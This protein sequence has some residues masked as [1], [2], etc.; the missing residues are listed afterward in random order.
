[1]KNKKLLFGILVIVIVAIAGVSLFY[2]L[3][4][5]EFTIAWKSPFIKGGEDWQPAVDKT[6]EKIN[7]GIEA[8]PIARECYNKSYLIETADYIIEG[9]IEKVEEKRDMETGIYSYAYLTIEDYIKGKPLPANKLQINVSVRAPY[10]FTSYE[11]KK[12]RIYLRR[13]SKGDIRIF[14]GNYGVE[15]IK[16][17]KTKEDFCG[18]ST[19]GKCSSDSDCIVGGCSAQVCQS[20][21]EK[22]IITTCEWRDCYNAKE[23]NLKCKCVKGGCQWSK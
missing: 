15:E 18:W 19:D 10:N 16:L 12:V 20:K 7:V 22:S 4:N 13:W 2:H 14:C 5:G 21:Y 6:K 1:M 9:T 8:G 23:Y 3:N 11:G 17:E